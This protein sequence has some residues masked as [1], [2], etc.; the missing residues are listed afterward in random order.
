MRMAGHLNMNMREKQSQHYSEKYRV[1]GTCLE[2]SSQIDKAVTHVKGR[3]KM[4]GLD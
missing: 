3:S 4:A 2:A 1:S